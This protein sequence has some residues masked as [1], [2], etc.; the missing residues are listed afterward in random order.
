M[1][2]NHPRMASAML[3]I[4][5]SATEYFGDEVSDMSGMFGIHA[6]EHRGQDGVPRDFFIE[7]AGQFLQPFRAARPCA[8]VGIKSVMT[9]A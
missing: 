2:A 5:F 9:Q 7:A 3:S 1:A 6:R 8:K 4:G